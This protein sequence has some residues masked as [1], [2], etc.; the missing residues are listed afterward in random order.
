MTN[1][2]ISVTVVKYLDRRFLMMRYTD[3]VT[4]KKKSRS[5]QTTNRREAE[6]RAAKWEAELRDG[7][8][9]P[10]SKILW[11]EFR[12]QYEDQKLASLADKS[13]ESAATAMNHLER[14]IAPQRLVSVDSQTL[15]RFQATLRREGM[16]DTT[17]AAYLAH[18]RPA[19]SWAVSMG[20]LLKVPEMHM[21]VRVKGRKL[22]RGRP[23]A[24]DEFEAMIGSIQAVRKHDTAE[25]KHYLRGIWLS[26]L[27]LEESVVLSWDVEAAFTV[28]LS[29]RHPRFRIYAEAEKGHQDRLLPMTPDFAELLLQTPDKVRTG[30]VFKLVGKY[31]HQPITPRRVGRIIS[32]IG[33]KSKVVV[34]KS[35]GKFA[36]AHDFR[37]S[38]GSRWARRVMPATLQL[39]MRHESIETTMKYYVDLEADELGDELWKSF[40]P[41]MFT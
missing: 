36:S 32:Q 30:R 35:D 7:R 22:M 17:I 41:D 2:E 38:F 18:L 8:F 14:V 27:R 21:P 15:S 6:R 16:K 29:G 20:M 40:G 13:R 23:L 34:N 39:L 25:W 28:D 12:E 1:D 19:L 24:N 10:T 9:Q 31:T 33:E 11:S 5:T 26:G 4:G 3:P 37:R